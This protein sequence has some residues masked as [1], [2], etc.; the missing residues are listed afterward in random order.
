VRSELVD[1]PYIAEFPLTLECRLGST[2]VVEIDLFHAE[3]LQAR[4]AA[5]ADI[6]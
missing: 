6:F 1:A 3:P 4:L 2:L 5:V